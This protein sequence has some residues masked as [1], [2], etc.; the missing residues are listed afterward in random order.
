MDERIRKLLAK[1]VYVGSSSWKYE[2]WKGLVYQRPYKSKKE[3]EE[4]CLSEYAE[5]YTAVG[6]DH[7]YYAWPTKATFER[8]VR[9][10]PEHF[11]FG[12]K[13]TEKIT[14]LQYP[15]LKRYGKD[16]GK[17]NESFLDPAAFAMSFLAPLEDFKARLGPVMLEF[18]QFYPGMLSSGREF[19]ERLDRFFDG[20]KEITGFQYAVEM[21]NSNWLKEP[22][23]D[24]LRRHG[25]AHVFNSWTRMPTLLE[26]LELTKTHPQPCFPA[27]LLLQ[28]GTKYAEAVEAFSPYDKI[29]EEQ[30][31][32]RLGGARLIERAI[33][34]GVPAY[35][36]VNNRAEGCAPRT[37]EAILALLRTE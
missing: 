4:T 36:F 12:L 33:E 3:F 28:P 15:K 5:Q 34:L 20:I 26:Q 22:Y 14:V 35:V 24:V 2:G 21:R 8:Y 18:S 11:R 37:I 13:A 30:P 16:A 9:Q 7:T 19:V 29:C 1:R 6:V 27:R 25:V 10:T 32:L 23:F 17:P 31:D